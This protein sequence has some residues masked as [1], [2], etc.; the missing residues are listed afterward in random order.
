MKPPSR[1]RRTIPRNQLL[2]RINIPPDQARSDARSHFSTPKTCSLPDRQTINCQTSATD[3]LEK[4]RTSRRT[5]RADKTGLRAPATTH[6][7]Q[8]RPQKDTKKALK[9]G[10]HIRGPASAPKASSAPRSSE[11]GAPASTGLPNG[12]HRHKRKRAKE[13]RA[14]ARQHTP[15]SPRRGLQTASVHRGIASLKPAPP[16]EVY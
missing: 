9:N 6:H 1:K 13:E 12:R 16:L 8:K 4:D 5:I 14:K 10:P 15:H 2:R 7:Q 3:A 11:Q